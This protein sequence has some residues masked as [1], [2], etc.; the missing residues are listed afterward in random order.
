MIKRGR[1]K[2]EKKQMRGRPGKRQKTDKFLQ[3]VQGR[4]S[5]IFRGKRGEGK[6][7][8]KSTFLK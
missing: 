6:K 7:K 8:K 5:A 4:K 2:E 1:R 3:Q